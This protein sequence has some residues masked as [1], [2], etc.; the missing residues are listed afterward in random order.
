MGESGHLVVC[1]V[2]VANIAVL[3]CVH[4]PEGREDVHEVDGNIADL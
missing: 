1:Q 3:N 4:N 2:G